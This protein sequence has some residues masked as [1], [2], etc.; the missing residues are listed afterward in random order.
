MQA[1]QTAPK[2]QRGDKSGDPRI[3]RQLYIYAPHD[4]DDDDDDGGGDD[5]G[6]DDKGADLRM[7]DSCISINL[8]VS[9]P[10]P[11]SPSRQWGWNQ[12]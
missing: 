9:P 7:D 2:D 1:H 3:D 6:D 11:P 4:D 8:T 5:D 12:G 10:P